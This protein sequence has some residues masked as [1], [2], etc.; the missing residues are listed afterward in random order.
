M[1]FSTAT[2]SYIQTL[3]AP[4]RRGCLSANSQRI[5]SAYA[6]I[7]DTEFGALDMA[8][9]C[10]VKVKSFIA[11]L[12]AENYAP[13]TIIGI[14]KVL[15]AI[16]GSVRDSKG[17]RLYSAK[18]QDLTDLEF[19][20]LPV[21]EPTEEICASAT[22]VEN[23]RDL[24]IVAF[25]AATG[26]RIS[27]CLALSVGAEGDCY[28]TATSTVHIRKT[29]KTKAAARS[30]ILPKAFATWFAPFVPASG[31]LFA[32]TYQQLHGTL[33]R[34]ALPCPHAYRRHRATWLRTQ[35]CSEDVIQCQLGHAK[36]TVTDG[37]SHAGQNLEFVRAEIERCGLGFALPRVAEQVAA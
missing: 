7:L 8:A 9:V 21:L 12:R 28:D 17:A 14:F 37:Y 18:L 4:R 15:K 29:L 24:P 35:R 22:D 11:R 31:K 27:E 13:S 26:L 33:Q 2:T 36:K 6:K 5:Y 32:T 10:N 25:L 23:A 30:I 19:I 16:V 3:S 1:N 34:D 20:N